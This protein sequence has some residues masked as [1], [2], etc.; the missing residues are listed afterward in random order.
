MSAHASQAFSIAH[1]TD[2]EDLPSLTPNTMQSFCLWKD[3]LMCWQSSIIL[4][5]VIDQTAKHVKLIRINFK[6]LLFVVPQ[7]WKVMV[8]GVQWKTAPYPKR[9]IT[10]FFSPMPMSHVVTMNMNFI[11]F[12]PSF[13][14]DCFDVLVF[15]LCCCFYVIYPGRNKILISN[16]LWAFFHHELFFNDP[17]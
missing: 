15:R 9:V 3:L 5:S 13:M 1:C 11:P 16:T 4:C 7:F 2:L 17:V 12:R 6:T 10:V 14:Y 8:H